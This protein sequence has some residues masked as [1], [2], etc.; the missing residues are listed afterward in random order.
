MI[1]FMV[2]SGDFKFSGG[3]SVFL[4][5]NFAYLPKKAF[6]GVDTELYV[7]TRFFCCDSWND[8]LLVGNVLLLLL[9]S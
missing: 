8:K 9:L 5:C 2:A 3:L 7:N 4:S 6:D 1:S